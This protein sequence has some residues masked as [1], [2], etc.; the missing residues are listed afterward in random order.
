LWILPASPAVIL[1]SQKT[2]QPRSP[3]ALGNV[4][5]DPA[6]LLRSQWLTVGILS[7]GCGV[8]VLAGLLIL[9][10]GARGFFAVGSYSCPAIGCHFPPPVEILTFP[11]A[12]VLGLCVAGLIFVGGSPSTLLGGGWGWIS[13]DGHVVVHRVST[14]TPPSSG[15]GL[16][17]CRRH[18]YGSSGGG[19]RAC[20]ECMAEN[21]FGFGAPRRSS[22]A[23]FLAVEPSTPRNW[24]PVDCAGDCWIASRNGPRPRLAQGGAVL[25]AVR[26]Y[27]GLVSARCPS[28]EWLR[29][30]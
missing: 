8:T 20:C 7:M 30:E 21:H 6:E 24:T 14:R 19:F 22:T 1:S 18:P 2:I 17:I 29:A 13:R 11:V 9:W 4:M 23:S 28:V 25:R 5:R 12:V 16:V 15:G 26:D 10:F 3:K 27:G